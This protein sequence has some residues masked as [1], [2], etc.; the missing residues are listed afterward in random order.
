MFKEDVEL[1]KIIEAAWLAGST[2]EEIHTRYPQYSKITYKRFLKGKPKGNI[3]TEERS[4]RMRQ[5]VLKSWEEKDESEKRKQIEHLRSLSES[6]KGVS[7]SL[8]PEHVQNIRAH[9]SSPE[10]RNILIESNKRRKKYTEIAIRDRAQVLGVTL[11]GDLSDSSNFVD[12]MWPDG[13]KSRTEIKKLMKYGISRPMGQFKKISQAKQKQEAMGLTVTVDGK[14]ADITY[15]SETWRQFWDGCPNSTTLRRIKKIE[16]AEMITKLMQ[17]GRSLTFACKEAGVDPTT[18]AR[19][20]KITS[21]YSQAVGLIRNF[22][23][24]VQIDGAVYNKRLKGLMIRPDILCEHKKLIIE[25][26]GLYW[27]TEEYKNKEYHYQRAAL[28]ESMGYNL[29][30]FSQWEVENR[31][32]IVDSM[33]ANKMGAIKN[34]VGA[35]KCSVKDLTVAEAG[36]FFRDNHLKGAGRG[37][38]IGLLRDDVVVCA[39]R[40]HQCPEGISISRFCSKVGW[41]VQG[42]Y[43]KLLK[44][45]PNSP[46]I[47][48]VDIRHGTG[49]HLENYGFKLINEHIG[50]E[51][52]NGYEA[53]NR[54]AFLS[55]G[56]TNGLKRYWDYGQRKYK[57]EIVV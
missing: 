31:R 57:K 40:W 37:N 13:T 42:G 54:R 6:Q 50:F 43:S 53:F 34:K 35:R 27:H 30:V 16:Q 15:K 5:A 8:A 9:L 7:L 32:H 39:I 21:N 45:L 44:L 14:F 2:L 18:F 29:L 52:T 22:E 25:I 36:A 26:D 51:W 4:E 24:L 28:Y 56:N 38:C 1:Q 23:T 3:W 48:F 55:S 33:I 49:R 47:N 46:V 17:E 10:M 19:K 41:S 20:L 11:V 12:V